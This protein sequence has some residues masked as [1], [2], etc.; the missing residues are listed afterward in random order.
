[1]DINKF[2]GRIGK[3]VLDNTP[4][5]EELALLVAQARCLEPDNI[6]TVASSLLGR[7]AGF[8]EFVSDHFLGMTYEEVL[9]LEKHHR[10]LIELYEWMEYPDFLAM[11]EFEVIKAPPQK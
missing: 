8:K 2:A 10:K 9:F 11:L 6:Q 1:M 5:L 4:S 7:Y 3:E